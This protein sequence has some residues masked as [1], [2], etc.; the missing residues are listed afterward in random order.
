M[1]IFKNFDICQ[2]FWYIFDIF[3]HFPVY[4]MAK[5]VID[6][7]HEQQNSLNLTKNVENHTKNFDFLS[8]MSDF[9]SFGKCQKCTKI[10]DFQ[11]LTFPVHFPKITRNPKTVTGMHGLSSEIKPVKV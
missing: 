6:N 2:K 4:K 9:W 8:K 7:Q 1:I 10:F 5:T 3:N 11:L